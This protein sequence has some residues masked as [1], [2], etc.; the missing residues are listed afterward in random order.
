MVGFAPGLAGPIT[1]T[2][3]ELAPEQRQQLDRLVEA[4]QLGDLPAEPPA[5]PNVPTCRLCVESE[6]GE[7]QEVQFAETAIPPHVR[8]LVEWL[9][10]YCGGRSAPQ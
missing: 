10:G 3:D 9:R 4:A 7:H 8:P 2:S 5:H 6:Q 1:I